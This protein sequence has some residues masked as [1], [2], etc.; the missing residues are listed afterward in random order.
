MC[1]RRNAPRHWVLSGAKPT[2]GSGPPSCSVTCWRWPTLRRSSPITRRSR[3]APDED[4]L[5]EPDAKPARKERPK[6]HLV[7]RNFLVKG[8]FIILVNPTVR[9]D[10]I[11]S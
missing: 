4:L 5:D 10:A 9:L 2:A 3:S 1:S 11:V 6:A 8:L 7:G